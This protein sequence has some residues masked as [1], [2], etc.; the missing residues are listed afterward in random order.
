MRDYWL[1]QY[2]LSAIG[3]GYL[4]IVLIVLALVLWLVKGK[5]LKT[6]ALLVVLGLAS[7]LPIQ[8]Y[9]E[10]AKEKEA[11][12]AFRARLAKMQALFDERCKVAGEKIYKAISGVDGVFLLTNREEASKSAQYEL[13]DQAGDDAHG[14][15]YVETFF[16]G[17]QNEFLLTDQNKI[18]A[19][20]FVEMSANSDDSIIR[21]T[22]DRQYPDKESLN[23]RPL[24]KTIVTKRKARYGVLT[25]D[26]STPQ[27]RQNWIA[28][29]R[30]KVVDLESKEIVAERTGY[31]FDRGLGST[32]RGRLPWAFAAYAACPAFPK[33]H[34]QYPH[35]WGLTRNFVE[36]VL[37][38]IQGE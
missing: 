13:K 10:Y 14:V 33:L 12:D 5:V 7:I 2:L 18:G 26:L 36:K 15:G 31:I 9:Q 32:D 20:R 23:K 3:W 25:E 4:I 16:M 6:V 24:N 1:T 17:K 11:A 30:I 37:K 28:A 29:S 27:D 22:D 35:K 38:P 8:G 34:D 19:Y 21:Y